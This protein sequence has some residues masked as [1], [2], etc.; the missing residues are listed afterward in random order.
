MNIAMNVNSNL[1]CFLIT[2]YYE[3]ADYAPPFREH[4]GSQPS[5]EQM[6]KLVVCNDIRPTIPKE[7]EM[8]KVHSQSNTKSEGYDSSK[9]R[10]LLSSQVE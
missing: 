5:N 10:D 4:V 7:W 3:A 1:V 8:E 9:T 2:G 6:K